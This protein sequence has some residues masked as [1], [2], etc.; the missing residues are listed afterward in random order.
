MEQVKVIVEKSK[1]GYAAYLPDLKGCVSSGSSIRELK[2]KLRE[3]ILFHLDGMKE[4]NLPVPEVLTK[5]YTL[6]F[7]F[8]IETFLNYY[9]K[10]FTRRALSRMTGINESLLSQYAA[11]LKR[12]RRAQ[13]KRIEKG[14]H[15]L[16]NELLE[17]SL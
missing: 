3:A 4:D 5:N 12:P 17:V 16:A 8:D 2:D 11:G 14:L 6:Q 9:D 13:A 1:T 7:H 10:I 15:D